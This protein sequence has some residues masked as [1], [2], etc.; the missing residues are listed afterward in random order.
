MRTSATVS[1]DGRR[2]ETKP[3]SMG[4]EEEERGG[5]GFWGKGKV[6]G[7]IRWWKPRIT[8]QITPGRVVKHWTETSRGTVQCAWPFIY[9]ARAAFHGTFKRHTH[10]RKSE[11]RRWR[12]C[13]WVCICVLCVYIRSWRFLPVELFTCPSPAPPELCARACFFYRPPISVSVTHFTSTP[14][15]EANTVGGDVKKTHI[16]A[17]DINTRR[18]ENIHSLIECFTV[19]WRQLDRR[20]LLSP[21]LW[22]SFVDKRKL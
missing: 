7:A 3:N 8:P 17:F 5:K 9:R 22:I 14:R 10:E 13:M 11:A 19:K 2:E 6:V 12:M 21:F 1:I 16:R 4:S 18:L 20:R 15:P